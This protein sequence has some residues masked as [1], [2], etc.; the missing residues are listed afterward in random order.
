M[1]SR[2]V[3]P[4]LQVP[5]TTS[6]ARS[7]V[8]VTIEVMI[9][10]TGRP[11]M[12]TFKATGIGAAE[13]RTALERWIENSAFRPARHGSVSVPGIYRIMLEARIERR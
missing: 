12:S 3:A 5:I 13:N 6:G 9:D 7:P 11:D 4:Q 8:R 2:G 10:D 1:T